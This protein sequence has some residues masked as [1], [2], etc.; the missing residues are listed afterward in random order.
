SCG[1]LSRSTSNVA[2]N[3]AGGGE[4]ETERRSDD[5]E[6]QRGGGLLVGDEARAEAHRRRSGSGQ[7]RRQQHRRQPGH[8]PERA[9]PLLPTPNATGIDTTPAPVLRWRPSPVSRVE[10]YSRRMWERVVGQ[11]RAVGLLQRAAERPVHAYLLV[12]P[13]GSGLEDAARS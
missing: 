1:A 9:R 3:Q 6:R 11:E 13:R 8:L 7:Q 5:R 4:R 2:G 10:P 12:G